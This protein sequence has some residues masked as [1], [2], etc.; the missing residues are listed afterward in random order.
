MRTLGKRKKFPH[1]FAN[2]IE[3]LKNSKRNGNILTIHAVVYAL[4]IFGGRGVTEQVRNSKGGQRKC[5][6]LR[7]RGKGVDF[8]SFLCVRTLYVNDPKRSTFSARHS[9]IEI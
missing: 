7:T 3:K 8:L 1:L 5:V 9:S 6:G 4:T 2:K